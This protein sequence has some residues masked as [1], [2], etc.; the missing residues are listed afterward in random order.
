MNKCINCSNEHETYSLWNPVD[1]VYLCKDCLVSGYNKI[2]S[3][4][5]KKNHQDYLDSLP[6]CP[7]C[8]Q[9]FLK[10]TWQSGEWPSDG[11]LSR[12]GKHV[13]DIHRCQECDNEVYKIGEKMFKTEDEAIRTFRK[14]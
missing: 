9:T 11:R 3:Q 4:I 2:D 6:K 13:C 1:N 10:K 12:N 5:R 7:H 14:V 8:G